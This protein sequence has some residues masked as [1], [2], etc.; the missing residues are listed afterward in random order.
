MRRLSKWR[1][2]EDSQL[3]GLEVLPPQDVEQIGADMFKNEIAGKAGMNRRMGSQGT[4]CEPRDCLSWV[5][6]LRCEGSEEACLPRGWK[7]WE[8]GK[9]AGVVVI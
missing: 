1:A 8:Q 9:Q 4:L 3:E 2:N 5:K 6:I 7:G